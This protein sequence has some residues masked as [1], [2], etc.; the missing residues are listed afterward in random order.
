MKL[1]MVF[2]FAVLSRVWELEENNVSSWRQFFAQF[3][4]TIH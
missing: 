3:S 1:Q 4:F 2:K